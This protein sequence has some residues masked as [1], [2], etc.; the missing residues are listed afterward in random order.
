[1]ISLLGTLLGFGT[2]IVPEVLGYFK[3][4]QANKQ[5]LAMLEAKAKYA[6]QL[7][8]LKVKELDAQAEIEETKGLYEHDRSIDA[9][10]FVN[11]LRGSVRPILTY[12]FFIAFA[13]VKGVMIYA[14]IENQN[15]DWVT[16]VESAWDD[17]TQAIFSA[18]IAFWFGNRAMSKAHARISSKNG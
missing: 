16:A 3:Q 5:E 14:M 6:A 11:A 15:I 18:I 8:E 10:G 13:S 9:G 1:M 2:S 7:S 17:E 4:Q 12:L